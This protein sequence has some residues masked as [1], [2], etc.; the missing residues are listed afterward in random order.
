MDVTQV[1]IAADQIAPE[2]Q[3]NGRRPVVAEP[4]SIGAEKKRVREELARALSG[5]P[6]GASLF[7]SNELRLSVDNELERVI[8]TVVDSKTGEVVRTIPAEE[9][10]EAAKRLDAMLG[11]ILDRNV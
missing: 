10:V 2:R 9:L 4:Q 5:D 7:Q 11:Q 3:A 1:N 6:L 8:A